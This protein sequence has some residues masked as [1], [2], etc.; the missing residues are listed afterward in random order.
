MKP[1]MYLPNLIII[2]GSSRNV[3]KT[4]LALSLVRKYAA[5]EKIT[6]LKVSSLRPDE[7]SFHGNHTDKPVSKFRIL[8]EKNYIADKDTSKL[9]KA[10]AQ[11]VF[12]IE[13]TNDYLLPAFEE[14]LSVNSGKGPIICESGSLRNI[15]K[16]GLFVLLKHY[17]AALIK[18]GFQVSE[19][20]ADIT[21]TID[22][23]K[24]TADD[25]SQMIVWDGHCWRLDG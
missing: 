23:D 20:L 7:N 4:T 5:S 22:P 14:F 21:I 2:G 16:P 10:G 11:K 12:Y 17:D 8:E 19:A 6:G 15:V 1:L 25:L 13:A 9:L 3:G 24:K 18:P